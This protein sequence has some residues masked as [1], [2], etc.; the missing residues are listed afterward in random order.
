MNDVT[1]GGK[2]LDPGKCLFANSATAM[3][4]NGGVRG[5]V[6]RPLASS[7][8]WMEGWGPYWGGGGEGG[9]LYAHGTCHPPHHPPVPSYDFNFFSRKILEKYEIKLLE[10]K[11]LGEGV[12]R[13]EIND[14]ANLSTTPSQT[15]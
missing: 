13:E 3:A 1:V 6:H 15:F 9:S 12:K 7:R 11:T 10:S 8:G 4:S 5:V 14:R 2:D